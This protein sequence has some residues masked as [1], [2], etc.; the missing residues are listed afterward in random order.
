VRKSVRCGS[1]LSYSITVYSEISV[2]SKL[3]GQKLDINW[4]KP[5]ITIYGQVSRSDLSSG[6]LCD[7]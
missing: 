5:K 2:D 1:F 4:Q 6:P 3:P 7:L